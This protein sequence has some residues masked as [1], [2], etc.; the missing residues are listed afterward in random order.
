MRACE[1]NNT[2]QNGPDNK[3]DAHGVRNGGLCI[4]EN[5]IVICKSTL[6]LATAALLRGQEMESS[7]EKIRNKRLFLIKNNM[8]NTAIKLE[9]HFFKKGK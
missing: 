1:A 6:I 7:F 9:T 8:L 4:D 2:A 3:I 5:V